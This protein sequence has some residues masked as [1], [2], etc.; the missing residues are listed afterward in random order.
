ME[1][2]DAKHLRLLLEREALFGEIAELERNVARMKKIDKYW[3]ARIG[4]GKKSKAEIE[5]AIKGRNAT[6]SKDYD[7]PVFNGSEAIFL[8]DVKML[9]VYSGIYFAW[10]SSGVLEYVGKAKNIR[11]RLTGTH[12]AVRSN[13]YLGFCEIPVT[14]LF[15][16]EAYYIGVL[17]PL[18][19]RGKPPIPSSA[20]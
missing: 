4:E 16:A 1:H 10:H 8:S 14:D 2:L 13:H 6:L 18:L 17:R 9:P 15:Y 3:R 7:L 19:N 11:K 12:H 20:R 5:Q